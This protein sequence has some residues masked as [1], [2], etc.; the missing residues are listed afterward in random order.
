MKRRYLIPE[1]VLKV[2]T[3]QSW[4]RFILNCNGRKDKRLLGLL[5]DLKKNVDGHLSHQMTGGQQM[6]FPF[7][8]RIAGEIQ[9]ITD[10]KA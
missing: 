5:T 3:F 6:S 7:S 1:R 9:V 8:R 2:D 4:M 10:L